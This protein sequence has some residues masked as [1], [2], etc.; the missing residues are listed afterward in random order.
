MAPLQA[1]LPPPR[2]SDRIRVSGRPRGDFATALRRIP[3]FRNAVTVALAWVQV[4][5]PIVLAVQLRNPLVWFVAFL[6]VGR[7]FALLAILGH[8]AAHRLL[9]SSRSWNDA[10]GRWLLEAPAFVPLDVYRYVHL[11]HHRDELGPNEPD[12]GLYA[13]YPV[14]SRSFRRKLR[15][16][17]MGES[18]WKNLK[19]LLKALGQRPPR[20]QIWEI[21]L[22]QAVI[23]A[24]FFL[25]GW[26]QLYVLMWV[27]PWMT[28]WRVLNRL[29]AIAE[30][31]GLVA[32]DD[33]RATSHHMRQSVWA[34][35]WIVPYNTGW[36]VA[37]HVDAAV[38][39]RSL[40]RLHKALVEDGWYPEALT[41][42]SYTLFWRTA[43]GALPLPD[44]RSV[45]SVS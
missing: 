43:S 44:N 5:L 9:F 24:G 12:L 31:G 22:V 13:G 8:E 17:A 45:R 39:F 6:L 1:S 7:G 25:A 18:G 36:H 26:P 28:V 3:N 23:F 14:S 15:R 19:P 30:H 4:L 33:R 32:N 42:E 10:I 40:P 29:R 2:E 34:R 41:W 38:P 21:A 20:R 11:T 27:L 16:D 37:H 35:F